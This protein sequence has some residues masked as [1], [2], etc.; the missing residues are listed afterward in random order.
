M[1]IEM[2]ATMRMEDKEEQIAA[3]AKLIAD[4]GKMTK[5]FKALEKI[6]KD[7]GSTGFFVGKTMT[8]ADIAMWRLLGWFKGGAL[9]GIPKEVFDAYPSVLQHYNSIDTHAEIRKWMETRYAKKY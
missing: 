5:Y 6:L 4:D 7:N 1:G 2:G 3:R 9:D 8:I